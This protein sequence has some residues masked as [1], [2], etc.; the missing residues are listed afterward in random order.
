MAVIIDF[1][2]PEPKDSAFWDIQLSV[3]A[4]GPVN[5]SSNQLIQF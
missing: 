3:A 1:S 2:N 5:T 4:S